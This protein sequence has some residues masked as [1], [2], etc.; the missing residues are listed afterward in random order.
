MEYWSCFVRASEIFDIIN[1]GDNVSGVYLE[2]SRQYF[3]TADS[4]SVNLAEP[5]AQIRGT[6]SGR[7][8]ELIEDLRIGLIVGNDDIVPTSQANNLNWDELPLILSI[9][10]RK[11]Q[12]SDI[13]RPQSQIEYENGFR[14]PGAFEFT[15]YSK[16]N[17]N[18]IFNGDSGCKISGGRGAGD[19]NKDHFSCK[20]Q[21]G[22]SAWLLKGAI[23]SDIAE[24]ANVDFGSEDYED[25]FVIRYPKIDGGNQPNTTFGIPCPPDWIPPPGN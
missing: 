10:L 6:A 23:N 7:S 20:L 25:V 22:S 21:F 16:D 2:I 17:L 12:F 11:I 8:I 3:R 24:Y 4:Q 15:Y 14:T 5:L 18:K 1:D 9:P 13:I 19:V